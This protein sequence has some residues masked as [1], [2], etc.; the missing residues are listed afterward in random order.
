MN[1]DL[2]DVKIGVIY[3][4]NLRLIQCWRKHY[5]STD[6]IIYD[7]EDNIRTLTIR[8]I[9]IDQPEMK[10]LNKACVEIEP[11]EIKDIKSLTKSKQ[12]IISIEY[13]GW[14]S[15]GNPTHCRTLQFRSIL[16]CWYVPAWKRK[17][18]L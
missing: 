9:A 16:S 14:F 11:F 12:I 15:G 17:R 1:I 6:R 5:F 18:K 4:A 10:L 3:L 7:Q 8:C 2:E 13:D